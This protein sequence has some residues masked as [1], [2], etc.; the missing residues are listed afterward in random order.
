MSFSG[1]PRLIL[2]GLL[3]LCVVFSPLYAATVPHSTS[4][5]SY[6]AKL[7]MRNRERLLNQFHTQI[8]KQARYIVEGT[9]ESK[10]ALR[11]QNRQRI[12]QHPE[13]FPVPLKASDRPWQ[14][15]AENNH[16]LSS[17]R[18]HNI[19][20]VA[21]HRLEQQLGKPYV[22]GG[23][24]PQQGFD[25]SGL[26]FYA[27][28]KILASKLPRTAN[29][30]FHYRRATIVSDRDLRRGDLLFFHIHSR[31]IADH[32]GVYLGNGQFIESPRTGERIRISQ[33]AAP[34]WQDHYL[35]ARRI[36]T[37]NTII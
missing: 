37:E 11:Q 10:K 8:K 19:T 5:L 15:L 24:N 9:P 7:R 14:A 26:V 1:T 35:G 23:V 29:E 30:M 17:D 13:W 3:S 18:L 32:M 6:A 12:K 22:W 20:E 25:C 21:I 27:Y 33:L 2:P 28:N 34:F 16:F 36:L 31:E 4:P